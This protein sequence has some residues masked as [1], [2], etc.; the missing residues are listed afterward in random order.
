MYASIHLNQSSAIQR[1]I[2]VSEIRQDG[3]DGLQF[4]TVKIEDWDGK[5]LMS[6][7]FLVPAG[8]GELFATALRKVIA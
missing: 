2:T 5:G 3:K 1:S 6:V 8:R 7:S 4:D